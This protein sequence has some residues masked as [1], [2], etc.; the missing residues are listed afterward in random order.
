MFK[1]HPETNL[2]HS[3]SIVI[4]IRRWITIWVG[5][6]NPG[7]GQDIETCSKY[8]FIPKLISTIYIYTMIRF[9]STF[10]FVVYPKD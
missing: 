4:I 10:L 3:P 7:T 9:Q 6:Y 5:I 8:C 1:R 2:P